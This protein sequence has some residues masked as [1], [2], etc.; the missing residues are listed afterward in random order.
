VPAHLLPSRGRR[1]LKATP[2]AA[3]A[4]AVPTDI[5]LVEAGKPVPS[6]ILTK[7]KYRFAYED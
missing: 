7:E 5:I 3:P 4:D 6:F 2:A 1:V